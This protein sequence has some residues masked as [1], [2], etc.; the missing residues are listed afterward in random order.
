MGKTLAEKNI[1]LQNPDQ[2]K[3]DMIRNVE[4]SSA[5]EGIRLIRDSKTGLFIPKGEKDRLPVS[6]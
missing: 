4:T 6:Q 3:R 5:V 1:H 2:R